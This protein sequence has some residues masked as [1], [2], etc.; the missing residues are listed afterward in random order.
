[1]PYSGSQVSVTLSAPEARHLAQ[2]A[3]QLLEGDPAAANLI[4]RL[5][6][7]TSLA[8][9]LRAPVRLELSLVDA[10]LLR[11]LRYHARTASASL[12]SPAQLA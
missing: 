6:E 4:D 2:L 1:M 8:V 12:H 7:S 11:D 5:H 3:L 9:W 10:A